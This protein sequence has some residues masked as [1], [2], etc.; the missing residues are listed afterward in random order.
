MVLAEAN[1][2]VESVSSVVVTNTIFVN[3]AVD[4]SVLDFRCGGDGNGLRIARDGHRSGNDFVQGNTS[5]DRSGL[6]ID[7]R[8]FGIDVDNQIGAIGIEGGHNKLVVGQ[9]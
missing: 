5:M 2:V 8:Y 6:C 1:N 3:A 7:N 4:V 9:D